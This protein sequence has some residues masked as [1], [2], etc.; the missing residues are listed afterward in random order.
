MLEKKANNISVSKLHAILF[1]EADFNVAKKILFNT[2]MILQIE[3]NNEIP[4]EIVGGRRSQSAIHITI[5]KN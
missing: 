3:I 2:R 1:L 5:N 4:R